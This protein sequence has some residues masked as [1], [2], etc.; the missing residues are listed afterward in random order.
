MVSDIR[1]IP[2]DFMRAKANASV[3]KT[4]RHEFESIMFHW[5]FFPFVPSLPCLP[6][7][8]CWQPIRLRGA[9]QQPA[10]GVVVHRSNN[11]RIR[12]PIH[13]EHL[14]LLPS[15]A[16]VWRLYPL[17]RRFGTHHVN[18][19]CSKKSEPVSRRTLIVDTGS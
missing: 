6:R 11:K 2:Q 18:R 14:Y 9:P 3:D 17:Q 16:A 7:Q 19:E 10:Q 1:L 4:V 5:L 12:I 15:P 8:C 13:Q